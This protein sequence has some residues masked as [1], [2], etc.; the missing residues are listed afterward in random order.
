MTTIA[1][2]YS[3]NLLDGFLSVLKTITNGIK[4][5]LQ[6]LMIGFMVARQTRANEYVA[7][8]MIRY[9]EYRKDDYYNLL[10]E[11]N[12]KTIENVHKEVTGE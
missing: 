1:L 4:K 6:G 7:E 10:H 9:G 3:L 8:Q 2:N 5:I 12:R 11:L